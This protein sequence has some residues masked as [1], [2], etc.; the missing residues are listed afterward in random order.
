EASQLTAAM[1]PAG[2]KVEIVDEH[3]KT[4]PLVKV[5]RKLVEAPSREPAPEQP[6][7]RT[8]PLLLIGLAVGGF[9]GWSGYR[10][11]TAKP[12]EK[13]KAPLGRRLTLA[14]PLGAWT[15]L[16]GFLGFLF[17][18]FWTMTDHQVAYHNENLLQT[19]PLTAALPV[20]AI[21]LIVDK[22][23]A[24][25]AFKWLAY[26][27]AVLSVLGFVLQVLPW[28]DQVNGMIIAFLMP[29]WLGLAAG[30]F[31]ASRQTEQAV[32]KAEET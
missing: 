7:S 23:W 19:S 27:V 1:M 4:V 31:L 6:P 28:F 29:M 12:N 5:E 11:L 13:G 17:L 32:E 10:M 3:G 30:P 26:A 24:R 20:I 25:K 9:F 8:I 2:G 18:F 15:T 14:L 21:G 16:T 22:P